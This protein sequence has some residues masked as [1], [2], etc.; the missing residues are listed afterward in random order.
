MSGGILRGRCRRR[1]WRCWSGRS[2]PGIETTWTRCWPSATPTSS[3]C[4]RPRDGLQVVVLLGRAVASPGVSV[5]FHVAVRVHQRQRLVQ[6]VDAP[7]GGAFPEPWSQREVAGKVSGQ[8]E[9][10]EP[11]TRKGSAEARC[12]GARTGDEPTARRRLS[13]RPCPGTAQVSRADPHA[14]EKSSPACRCSANPSR[15]LTMPT[16]VMVTASAVAVW[17]RR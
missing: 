13:R 14:A 10:S 15:T 5:A 3:T 8:G 2:R 17:P 4:L 12:S 1:T 11:G 9:Q 16:P 6:R 7:V